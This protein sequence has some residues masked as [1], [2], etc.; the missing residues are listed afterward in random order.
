MIPAPPPH[1]DAALKVEWLYIYR[2]RLG[3]LCEDRIPSEEHLKIATEEA[4][5]HCERLISTV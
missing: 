1:F 2:E 3:M 5:A 4:T